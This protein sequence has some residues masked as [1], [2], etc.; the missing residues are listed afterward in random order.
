MVIE[1]KPVWDL[2]EKIAILVSRSHLTW[3]DKA[4]ALGMAA[5]ASSLSAPSHNAGKPLDPIG[6]FAD[7]MSLGME[8][9]VDLLKTKLV[10]ESILEIKSMKKRC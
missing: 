6:L 3:Q 1:N 7:Q 10:D 9:N 2:A 8:T 5:S 4:R